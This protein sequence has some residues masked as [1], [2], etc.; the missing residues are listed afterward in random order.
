MQQ[1]QLADEA[2]FEGV[3]EYVTVM[4]VDDETEDTP[5]LDHVFTPE[6]VADL[7]RISAEVKAGGVTSTME[8]VREHPAH[9]RAD[10]MRANGN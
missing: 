9:N 8:Q 5:N 4:L 7:D 6:R 1:I 3:D 2:G 10:W